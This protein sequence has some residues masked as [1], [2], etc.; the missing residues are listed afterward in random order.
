MKIITIE[1]LKGS[2]KSLICERLLEK[3]NFT[4]IEKFT[5]I[6]TEL[7][8]PVDF[9]EDIRRKYNNKFNNIQSSL[10]L[11]FY[12]AFF[13]RLENLGD[14]SNYLLNRGML[15]LPYFGYYGYVN[16]SEMIPFDEYLDVVREL[17]NLALDRYRKKYEE[18]SLFINLECNKGELFR[19]I[20][21]R[22]YKIPSDTFFIEH[23]DTYVKL[24]DMFEKETKQSLSRS[25]FL[26]FRNEDVKD[27]E[28]IIRI[29]GKNLKEKL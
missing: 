10:G 11:F 7:V 13:N 9:V 1:G 26:I 5:K 4:F 21:L 3:Y 17:H 23:Y 2:G 25:K 29:T 27:L 22:E 12:S 14:V 28:Q 20:K 6:R 18:N 15:S 16:S 8:R 19:R 24:N